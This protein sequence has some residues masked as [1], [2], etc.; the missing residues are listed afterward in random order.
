MPSISIDGSPVD[1]LCEE[2]EGQWWLAEN[3]SNK[4]PGRLTFSVPNGGRLI[5][6]GGL[7]RQDDYS[8]EF[9]ILGDCKGIH[10]T[11]NSGKY[12]G[13]SETS[14]ED[15]WRIDE[16]TWR[17]DEILIGGHILEGREKTYGHFILETELLQDWIAKA[18]P[19]DNFNATTPSLSIE[20]PERIEL[21]GQN[22]ATIAIDWTV[23]HSNNGT[24]AVIMV[25][26]RLEFNLQNGIVISEF[27][28]T[29]LIPFLFFISLATGSVDH[30]KFMT[31][32]NETAEVATRTGNLQV[33]TTNWRRTRQTDRTYRV[34]HLI[35]FSE[36]EPIL[37]ERINAWLR[38]FEARTDTLSEYYSVPYSNEMYSDD[39]FARIVRSL[40]SWHRESSSALGFVEASEYERIKE[41]L[42]SKLDEND[43]RIVLKKFNNS[44]DLR[45]RLEDLVASSTTKIKFIVSHSEAFLQKTVNTRNKIAHI[46]DARKVFNSSELFWAKMVLQQLFISLILVEIG[47]EQEMV[48]NLLER[49]SDWK[50]LAFT[51]DW[52][53]QPLSESFD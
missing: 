3:E 12:W 37:G 34:E 30:L 2:F 41:E 40:E 14:I 27:E 35:Q 31:A 7:S 47:F 16:E 24:N 9:I 26:P 8:R 39:T 21:Q 53:A 45:Q 6:N 38:V 28:K 48:A 13:G 20:V 11:V 22:G 49:T 4:V 29:F 42:K 43:S 15:S 5:L 10:I 1:N 51:V 23:K 25:S 52:H 50:Y 33:L 17:C 32:R 19:T 46:G 36:I 44:P 18:H